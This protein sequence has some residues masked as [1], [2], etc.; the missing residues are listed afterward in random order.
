MRT[1]VVDCPDDSGSVA[2]EGEI[3][4]GQ[5]NRNGA[6]TDVG[7]SADGPPVTLPVSH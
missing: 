7:V 1:Q 3:S 6:I 2:V 4:T 5:P